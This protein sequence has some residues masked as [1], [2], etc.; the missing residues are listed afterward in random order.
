MLLHR[1]DVNPTT[2]DNEA[3]R[4]ASF[5]GNTDIFRLLLERPDVDPSTGDNVAIRFAS[6]NGHTDIV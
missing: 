3:I 4:M 5:N 6:R 1:P 2:R